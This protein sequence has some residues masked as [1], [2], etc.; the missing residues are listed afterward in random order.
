MN[1]VTL[2]KHSEARFRTFLGFA[3]C[4]MFFAYSAYLEKQIK[5]DSIA[6]KYLIQLCKTEQ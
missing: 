6:E 5:A 1:S 3:V 4:S 2:H